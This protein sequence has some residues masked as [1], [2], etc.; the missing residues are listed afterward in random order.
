M[1][2]KLKSEI[3]YLNNAKKFTMKNLEQLIDFLYEKGFEINSTSPFDK[4]YPL[5]PNANNN[6]L[7]KLN[8]RQKDFNAV[9]HELNQI[10]KIVN[11]KTANSDNLTNEMRHYF[12]LHINKIRNNKVVFNKHH[13]LY[14]YKP[15]TD[16]LMIHYIENEEYEKCLQVKK[17]FYHESFIS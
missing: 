15:F 4:N 11:G 13:P 17:Q 3:C 10:Y 6:S 2:P 5:S 12:K 8:T 7:H 9:M 16:L 14:G 1:R